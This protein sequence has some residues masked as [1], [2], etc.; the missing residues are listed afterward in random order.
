ML[1]ND[2]ILMISE[3]MDKK[4]KPIETRFDQMQEQMDLRFNLMQGQMDTRLAEMQGQMDSR[5]IQMQGTMDSK[6]AEMQGTMDLRFDQMQNQ[7]DHMNLLM[8]NDVLPRLQNIESCY[9][10]TYRRYVVKMEEMDSL[11]LDMDVVKDVLKEHS[12]KLGGYVAHCGM[13]N[14]NE[15]LAE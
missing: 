7:L 5:F 13:R 2:D 4:L 11:K 15:Q 12:G 1:A 10:D 3:L 6:F 9:V 14:T 8:E